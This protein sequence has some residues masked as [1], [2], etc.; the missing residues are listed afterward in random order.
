M[1]TG[2]RQSDLPNHVMPFRLQ[3]ATG[4]RQSD[5]PNHVMP[6]RRLRLIKA[7]P[8][9]QVG[10]RNAMPLR[11]A[12]LRFVKSSR[13]AGLRFKKMCR[14]L[15]A[16]GPSGCTP[17]RGSHRESVAYC[18]PDWPVRAS[19]RSPQYTWGGRYS[20]LRFCRA[21]RRRKIRLDRAVCF[22]RAVRLRRRVRFSRRVRDPR[23]GRSSLLQA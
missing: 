7:R 1:A 14:D 13:R 18:H 10:L 22:R 11:L 4:R 21:V 5:L 15:A 12:G 8:L 20:V 17:R 23:L 9:C 6:L 3:M 19:R 2:R 16:A